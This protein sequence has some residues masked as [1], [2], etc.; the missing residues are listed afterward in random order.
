M[1]VLAS[2]VYTLFVNVVPER[3]MIFH[4]WVV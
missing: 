1:D 3:V 2:F 4:S